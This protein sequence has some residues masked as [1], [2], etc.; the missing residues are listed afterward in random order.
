MGATDAPEAPAALP[1]HEDPSWEAKPKIFHW[2]GAA[3]TVV[4]AVIGAGVLALPYAVGALGWIAGPICIIFFYLVSLAGC[5]MLASIYDYP[6]GT[7]QQHGRYIH[8]VEFVL[9]RCLRR[10]ELGACASAGAG[11]GEADTSCQERGLPSPP[12]PT[13]HPPR[14]ITASKSMQALANVACG[15]AGEG[16]AAENS[17]AGAPLPSPHPTHPPTPLCCARSRHPHPPRPNI[18]G[19]ARLPAH[20]PR[21]PLPTPPP[22]PTPPHPTPSNPLPQSGCFNQSWAMTVIFGGAQLLASQF[23]SLE[24]AWLMSAVGAVSSFGYS[25]IAMVLSAVKVANG[26]HGGTVG[27]IPGSPADKAFNCLNSLGSIAFAFG[28]LLILLEIQDTIKEPPRA[29]LSMR[30]AINA[31]LG[32][33][34]GFYLAVAVLGYLAFGNAVQPDIIVSFSGPTWAVVLAQVFVLLHMLGAWQVFAQPFFVALEG[35][36][37]RWLKV[38]VEDPEQGESQRKAHANALQEGLQATAHVPGGGGRLP[39]ATEAG[40]GLASVDPPNLSPAPSGARGGAARAA[41][42]AGGTPGHMTPAMSGLSARS[43]AEL[44]LRRQSVVSPFREESMLRVRVPAD[45]LRG[46]RALWWTKRRRLMLSVAVRCA[47]VVLVTI[48]AMVL[49]FFGAIVGLIGALTFWPLSIYFPFAMY[50]KAMNPPAWQ[51]RL[52]LVVAVV[53]LLVCIGGEA[54]WGPEGAPRGRQTGFE[55]SM[56]LPPTPI[57]NPFPPY[58]LCAATI[59]SVKN[60]ITSFSD[61]VIF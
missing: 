7:G 60:V 10:P 2:A 44:R 30:R 38:P 6:Y 55:I 37:F 51:K 18:R 39:A 42:S 20:G 36:V 50:N 35:Q 34:V 15:M 43:S 17:E 22:T 3:L 14:S 48:I 33:S 19:G 58:I 8:A 28:F 49:P 26:A 5:H 54:G 53:M 9:G 46:R 13:P 16:D 29:V 47:F 56:R 32:V 31:G 40:A 23:P 24:E 25:L 59:G 41:R 21:A 27:G 12:P 61:F 52:M 45:A 57:L 11:A 4:T 1:G